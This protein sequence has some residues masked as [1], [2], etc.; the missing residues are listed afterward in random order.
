MRIITIILLFI[1][2]ITFAGTSP[3]L[4]IGINQV[5]EHKALDQTRFGIIDELKENGYELEVLYSSAQGNSTLAK[6]IAD[7]FTVQNLDLAIAIGTL[8]AQ[9]LAKPANDGKLKVIFSSVTDPMSSGLTTKINI[10]GVSNFI[11][12]APQ[13]KLFKEIIPNLNNLGILYNSSE[14][15]SVSMVSKLEEICKKMNINLIKQSANNTLDSIPAAISLSKKV[16]AI[17]IS[18]DNTMLSALSGI[19]KATNKHNIPVFVSDSD[20]VSLGALAA[21]GPNQYYLGKQTAQI[22]IRILKGEG[23]NQQKI[24]YPKKLE[25]IINQKQAKKLGIMINNKI[26]AR[27]NKIIK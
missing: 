10:T 7:K 1:P 19:I 5:I 11:E 9:S 4:K 24:E 26:L 18:N 21:L 25:L 14:T 23:F 3:K 22:A 15:N 12:L 6:Q 20:A 17:F 8:S 27:A 13:I 16:Q 2:F